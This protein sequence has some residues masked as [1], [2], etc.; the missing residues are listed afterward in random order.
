MLLKKKKILRV[1]LFM[2]YGR[3]DFYNYSIKFFFIYMLCF[4]MLFN[5]MDA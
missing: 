4:K 1:R 3:E 5:V 2:R